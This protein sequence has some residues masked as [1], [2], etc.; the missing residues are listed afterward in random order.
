LLGER[1]TTM[2]TQI[3]AA[4][5]ISVPFDLERSCRHISRGFSKIYDQHFLRTLRQKA[6]AKLAMHPGLFDG[7]AL[8]RARSIYDFDDAVT[9]PVHG[10]ADAHDYYGR[11]S[12]LGFLDRIR[13]PTLLLSAVDDPFLPPAILDEVR[14]VGERNPRLT[15]EFPPHG[16]HAGFVGGRWPWRAEYYAEHRLCDFLAASL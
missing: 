2:A 5:A 7:A 1:G 14:M 8:D 11:S 6:A 10:F 3:R 15:L 13:V 12:S 16:G 9:A 4:G